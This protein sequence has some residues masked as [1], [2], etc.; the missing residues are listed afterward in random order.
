MLLLL[1]FVVL[2]LS[3]GGIYGTLDIHQGVPLIFDKIED[4]SLYLINQTETVIN[5][6]L[7][8]QEYNI[9][10]PGALQ[11]TL[12]DA[13]KI[14]S[15][16]LDHRSDVDAVEL[17][18]TIFVIVL[19]GGVIISCLIGLL[20]ALFGWGAP[21]LCM[22]I[23]LWIFM[24]ITAINSGVHLSVSVATADICQT[25]DNYLLADFFDVVGLDN[26]TA[27]VVRYYLFCSTPVPPELQKF[28]IQS[29]ELVLYSD[30]QYKKAVQDHNIPEMERWG[31]VLNDS[32]ALMLNLRTLLLCNVSAQAYNFTKEEICTDVLLGT[33]LIMSTEFVTC[34]LGL[35]MLILG[36]VGFKRFPRRRGYEEIN[37]GYSLSSDE[38]E[39]YHPRDRIPPS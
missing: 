16:I 26:D 5:E 10:V 29:D 28:T 2:A 8:L 14:R 32:M 17:A 30:A 11:T 12:D 21:S 15:E 1:I 25:V 36:I 39:F 13:E 18:R 3:A 20:A 23:L 4:T 9:T 33:F 7:K 38:R 22:V 19:F 37:Q 34:V 27:E 6:A 24:I 35:G 31:A